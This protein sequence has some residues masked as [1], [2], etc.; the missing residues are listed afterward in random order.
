MFEINKA[1]VDLSTPMLTKEAL[2]ELKSTISAPI[3]PSERTIKNVY[4]IITE[5]TMNVLLDEVKFGS[6]FGMYERLMK[7]EQ[8]FFKKNS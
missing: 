1:I 2:E 8:D 5:N 7:T 4:N 6:L 3:D